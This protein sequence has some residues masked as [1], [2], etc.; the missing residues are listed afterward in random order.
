[1]D[2]NDTAVYYGRG[3][4]SPDD[5]KLRLYPDARLPEEIYKR[6]KGAGFGWAPKQ[7]C[8][9]AQMWTP[10]R[11]DLLIELCGDVVD[12]D[13]TIADRAE[14]RAERF[15]D[16]SDKRADDAERAKEAVN[17]ITDGIPMGQPILVG[18][19]SERRARKDAEKIEA[20]LRKAVRLFD[21]SEYWKRRAARVL[22]HAEYKERPEVRARRI[23]GIEA[24]MRKAEKSRKQSTGLLKL[25]NS[26][27]LTMELAIKIANH[28]DHFSVTI[29]ATET[30]PEKETHLWDA[31]HNG[32]IDHLQAR[33]FAAPRHER[34]VAYQQRW[35]DHCTNRLVYERAMLEDSGGLAAEGVAM[36]PGGRVLLD[37]Q[38]ATIIRVN[39]KDGKIVSV[40]T[41]ARYGRVRDIEEIKEYQPPT[42]EAAEAVKQATKLPPLCN[43]PGE[44]FLKMTAEEWKKRSRISDYAFARTI[45]A[46]DTTAAHRVRCVVGAG[47]K[48]TQVFVTDLKR[49]DAPPIAAVE[50]DAPVVP[51]AEPM[52]VTPIVHVE[53]ERT[54]FDDM[55]D[56]LRA[57]V[58][59]FTAPQLFPTPISLADRIIDLA[60]IQPGQRVLEPSAGTGRL[61]DALA[62]YDVSVTAV[63]HSTSLANTLAQ[64]YPKMHVVNTDF[65]EFDDEHKFDTVVMNPP[66]GG[67]DDIKHI[68]HALSLLRPGGR[69]VALCAGGPR[70]EAAL[71]PL[72]T[73]NGGV[74][75]RLPEGTFKESGTG[76][77]VVL[78]AFSTHAQSNDGDVQLR[79]AV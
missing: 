3:T 11:Y 29:P 62:D 1:V 77:N 38:W 30:Q 36:E 71:R 31:L 12:D 6:L 55:R 19:S 24:D 23:K 67:A 13:N 73:E 52:A 45:D 53:H 16:Y 40:T 70:Q 66:F 10:E 50:E 9:Y 42:Q 72:V 14:V 20:G 48:R 18:H 64:R 28:F 5:N 44:G 57:G 79:L 47:F 4:Y 74:W 59:T 15:E 61:L 27:T 60:A 26:E 65:L 8:F 69:I 25:W 56:S 49:T 37:K 22:R 21:T 41:N 68:T 43:Y 35:I 54:E 34:N 51:R 76:V 39:K 2:T 33:A 32:R 17:H 7:E 78:L 46:T 75:E 58:Q 63:E